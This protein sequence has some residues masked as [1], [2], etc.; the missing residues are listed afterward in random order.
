MPCR[1]A[2]EAELPG[3]HGGKLLHVAQHSPARLPRP[4]SSF[5]E[6]LPKARSQA[7]PHDVRTHPRRSRLDCAHVP[8][9]GKHASTG[10]LAAIRRPQQSVWCGLPLVNP[11]CGEDD[12][13]RIPH[14][15]GCCALLQV[16]V[17]LNLA[18]AL[19]DAEAGGRRRLTRLRLDLAD[20]CGP[21]LASLVLPENLP[22]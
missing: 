6:E 20:D 1:P 8:C 4:P 12:R 17:G 15:H 22:A 3:P 13:A 9:K 10:K 14:L 21:Q 7:K 2:P 18:P 19:F 16:W 11:Y 5:D